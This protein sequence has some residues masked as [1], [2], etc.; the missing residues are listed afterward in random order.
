MGRANQPKGA[1]ELPFPGPYPGGEGELC[2]RRGYHR[3]DT[4][5]AQQ[6]RLAAMDAA[7]KW[8][9]GSPNAIDTSMC[10]G[11]TDQKN[12]LGHGNG[13]RGGRE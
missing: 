1:L 9:E 7:K 5:A 11:K 13:N 12:G 8:A 6:T 10:S 3:Q 4:R 2:N